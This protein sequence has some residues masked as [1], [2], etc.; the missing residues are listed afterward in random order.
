MSLDFAILAVDGGPADYLPLSMQLHHELM[1]DASELNLAHFL[2]FK[3][4]YRDMEIA[5]EELAAVS[6]DIDALL[7]TSGSAAARTFLKQL[8]RLISTAVANRK[9]LL[10]MAD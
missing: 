3:Q 5:P 10:A 4:Y 1:A 6:R 7:A 2:R 8:N 9:P